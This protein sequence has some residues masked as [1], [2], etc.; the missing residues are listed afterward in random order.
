[1]PHM[2]PPT[3][4]VQGCDVASQI[5]P[6]DIDNLLTALEQQNFKAVSLFKALA[7]TLSARLGS[8]EM[9]QLADAI[10]GLRFNDAR[11]RLVKLSHA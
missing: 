9:S 5:D 11:E 7:P 2:F 6:R 8:V 3:D 1:M 4:S 10:E